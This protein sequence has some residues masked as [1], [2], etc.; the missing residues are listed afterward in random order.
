MPAKSH[1]ANSGEGMLVLLSPAKSINTDAE[2]T[3][4]S[5]S[6]PGFVT[7]TAELL[8]TLQSYSKAVLQQTLG[9]SPAL[10]RQVPQQSVFKC[11]GA[12]PSSI[13]LVP[14]QPKLCTVSVLVSAGQQASWL[15]F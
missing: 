3:I 7:D 11:T 5:S 8:Q 6:T 1:C 4:V 12:R 13:S 10:A 14:V 15:C 2:H 9:V